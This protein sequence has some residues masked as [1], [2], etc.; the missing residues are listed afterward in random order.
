MKTWVQIVKMLVLPKF[1][2]TFVGEADSYRRRPFPLKFLQ[3]E[4][5]DYPCYAFTSELSKAFNHLGDIQTEVN[6]R[7]FSNDIN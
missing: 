2:W 6:L 1:S 7:E 4:C 3:Y 5:S